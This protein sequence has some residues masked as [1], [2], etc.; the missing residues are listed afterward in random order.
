M[1]CDKLEAASLK[2][3]PAQFIVNLESAQE[4]DFFISSEEQKLCGSGWHSFPGDRK[5][6]C[7]LARHAKLWQNSD[8]KTWCFQSPAGYNSDWKALM[9]VSV[10]ARWIFPSPF[11]YWSQM[12]V[13]FGFDVRKHQTVFKA[14]K[15]IK[16]EVCVLQGQV[17]VPVERNPWQWL[18]LC[19][20]SIL[21]GSA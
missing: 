12:F 11:D 15:L 1:V 9:P 13:L 5:L 7:Q 20:I 8:V 6:I 14:W 21:R 3:H 17:A 16:A 18:Q 2:V 19:S 4:G 10:L